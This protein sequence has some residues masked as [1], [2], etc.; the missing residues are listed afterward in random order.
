[1]N[2]EMVN[3]E[4]AFGYAKQRTMKATYAEVHRETSKDGQRNALDH[5]ELPPHHCDEG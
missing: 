1:M 5:A 2:L 3:A 4:Y